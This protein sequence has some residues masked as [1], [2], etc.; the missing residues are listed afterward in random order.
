MA[1]YQL[2]DEPYLEKLFVMEAITS[3]DAGITLLRWICDISGFN[4]T[5]MSM[6]DA[7]RRDLWLTLRQYIDVSKLAQIEHH[8]LANA[9]MAVRAQLR[10]LDEIP[11][12][13]NG[14]A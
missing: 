10:S 4:K 13:E 7:V 2:L 12:E 5:C 6:E 14:N 9:Q 11:K 8:E 1:D 3:S